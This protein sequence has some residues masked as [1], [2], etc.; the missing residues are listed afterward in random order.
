MMQMQMF[1]GVCQQPNI[2]SMPMLNQTNLPQTATFYNNDQRTYYQQNLATMYPPVPDQ[3]QSMGSLLR[4][5]I[6]D[7]DF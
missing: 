7:T 5:A 1:Q 6:D 3:T 2:P 4:S